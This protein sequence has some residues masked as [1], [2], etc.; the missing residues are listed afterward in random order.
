MY[1]VALLPR[2]AIRASEVQLTWLKPGDV[3][4]GRS[5]VLLHNLTAY[6]AAH[7]RV[8]VYLVLKATERQSQMNRRER[9]PEVFRCFGEESIA[10][11]I[12]KSSW[13][14]FKRSEPV[15]DIS[16]CPAAKVPSIHCHVSDLSNVTGYGIRVGIGTELRAECIEEAREGTTEAKDKEEALEGTIGD[17]GRAPVH[18]VKRWIPVLEDAQCVNALLKTIYLFPTVY[19]TRRRHLASSFRDCRI[20]CLMQHQALRLN[21]IRRECLEKV[22]G[23]QSCNAVQPLEHE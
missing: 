22:V 5:A 20:Q 4:V 6:L 8:G 17:H 10:A 1:A 21:D 16:Y 11:Y 14:S 13:R 18:Y 19:M 2:H 9:C 7:T 3:E 15:V 23:S 12:D